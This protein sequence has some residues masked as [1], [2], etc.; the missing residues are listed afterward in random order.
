MILEKKNEHSH[1][2]YA[3]AIERQHIRSRA[4]KKAAEDTCVR[5]SEIIR[6]EILAVGEEALQPHDL[7]SN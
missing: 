3:Q 7:K 2:Q 6:S 4:K 5:P 1:Q